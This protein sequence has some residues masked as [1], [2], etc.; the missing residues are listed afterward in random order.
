MQKLT[1]NTTFKQK[2]AEKERRAIEQQEER[3]NKKKKKEEMK[4]DEQKLLAEL[5]HRQRKDR[6]AAVESKDG[7]IEDNINCKY[8]TIL[9]KLS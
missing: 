8:S 6:R 9:A 4:T 1:V 5:R 3:A 7:A 2:R